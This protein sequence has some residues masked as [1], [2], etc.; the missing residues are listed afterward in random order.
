MEIR[1]IFPRKC[2]VKIR[3]SDRVYGI[4]K[5]TA[6]GVLTWNAPSSG[7]YNFI[8]I[9]D[10]TN[11]KM[12]IYIKGVADTSVLDVAFAGTWLTGWDISSGVIATPGYFGL[13]TTDIFELESGDILETESGDILYIG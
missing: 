12:N 4:Y 13:I 6:Q 2:K 3:D 7:Y 8:N 10:I 9:S 11:S 5:T 1:M